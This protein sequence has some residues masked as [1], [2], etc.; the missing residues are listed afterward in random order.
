MHDDGVE[1]RND[2]ERLTAGTAGVDQ[3]GGSAG[4]ASHHPRP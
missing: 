2:V 3:I 1:R 4:G